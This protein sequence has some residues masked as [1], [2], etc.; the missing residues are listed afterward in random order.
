MLCAVLSR[1]QLFVTPWTVA[2]QAP[3]SMGNL[4]AIILEWVA[5]P[6][7]RG[8]F[9]PRD[10]THVSC[11]GRQILYHRA[12]W[13]AQPLLTRVTSKRTT[14]ESLGITV[15]QM[16][17]L[18]FKQNGPLQE[19]LITSSIWFSPGSMSIIKKSPWVLSPGPLFQ[20]DPKV[21]K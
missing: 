15:E 14:H 2:C 17:L 7:T 21:N 6:S 16:H 4:Q 19:A 18:E 20:K 13:E 8:F 12:T 1:G 3:L 9:Q 5:M 10:W 11:V